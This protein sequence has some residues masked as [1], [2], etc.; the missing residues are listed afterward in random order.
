[1]NLKCDFQLRC[2]QILWLNYTF[3]LVMHYFKVKN[4][5]PRYFMI[6]PSFLGLGDVTD[7]DGV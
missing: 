1:M 4:L 7:F 5:L 6:M 3:L 2:F